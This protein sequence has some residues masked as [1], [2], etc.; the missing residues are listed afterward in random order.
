MH[1]SIR[2]TLLAAGATLLGQ[3]VAAAP[4]HA[5]GLRRHGREIERL[6]VSDVVSGT[7]GTH[8]VA[9]S[10]DIYR[11]ALPTGGFATVSC[12]VLTANAT[13]ANPCQS[14]GGTFV[15][16]VASLVDQ[17]VDQPSVGLGGP[18]TT[19]VVCESEVTLTVAGVGIEEFPALTVC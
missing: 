18:L 14:A 17:P 2:F 3:L 8:H 13:T 7:A 16:Q 6:T 11:F 19:V 5:D 15:S 1:R 12:V 9:G 4:A 10:V